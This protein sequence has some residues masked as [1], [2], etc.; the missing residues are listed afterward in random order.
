M[1]D[2]H[3]RRLIDEFLEIGA[4]TRVVGSTSLEIARRGEALAVKN[5]EVVRTS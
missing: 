5:P 2:A 4:D 3:R 1:E